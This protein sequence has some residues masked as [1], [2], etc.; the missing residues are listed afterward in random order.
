[1]SIGQPVQVLRLTHIFQVAAKIYAR[2][3]PINSEIFIKP[4]EFIKY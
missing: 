4:E 1:M 2:S 3:M